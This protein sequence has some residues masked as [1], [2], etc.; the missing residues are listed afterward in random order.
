MPASQVILLAEDLDDDILLIRMALQRA[1]IDNPLHIVR[2]G[3][4]AIHYLA[5]IGKY[6][7]RDVY[8]LPELLLLDLK[9]PRADGFEVLQW[10]RSRPALRSLIIIVLTV[11]EDIRDANRAYELGAS[12]F[13]VKPMDFQN[14]TALGDLIRTHWPLSNRAPETLPPPLTNRPTPPQKD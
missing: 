9:M 4:Q 11:S 3:E 7:A 1:G 2:D 10:V 13:L 5:G 12:S 6:S 8:P 14:S